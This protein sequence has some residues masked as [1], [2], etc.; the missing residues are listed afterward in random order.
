MTLTTAGHETRRVPVYL[1]VTGALLAASI[2]LA[3]E[4]SQRGVPRLWFL[5]TAMA[6]AG[7]IELALAAALGE[8]R[9]QS[10]DQWRKRLIYS[11]GSG[12]LMA[13]PLGMVWLSVPHAGAGYVAFVHAFPI[14]M[15]WAMARLMGLE[16]ASHRRFVAV[17][18]GLAG[19]VTLA[20][21]KLAGAP[22]GA[23]GWTLI[24]TAIPVFLAF[25]NIYRSRF[26]PVGAP[27]MLL[28]GMMLLMAAISVI[29]VALWAEGAALP[30]FRAL[31]APDAW[32]LLIAVI[33][34]YTLQYV[35]FFKLQRAG[36]PVVL[37]LIGPVAAVLG[38]PAAVLW[39]GETLPAV[40]PLAAILT[41]AG[42]WLMLRRG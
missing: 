18:L 7:L 16:S 39:Q 23:I 20:S 37:S 35:T 3:Q 34:A 19:A 12:M 22:P 6:G 38:P 27:P 10:R 5:A 25:G 31:M 8:V 24:A 29:P 33:A 21:A 42:V 14:L 4:A 15:T 11:A 32:P 28:A 13:L 26:W 2:L 30:A 17:M 9:Q 36:G 1:G 41:A 40:F